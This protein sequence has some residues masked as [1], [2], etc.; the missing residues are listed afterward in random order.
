VGGDF[1]LVLK[2]NCSIAPATFACVFAA[3]AVAVLGIGIGFAM[4][5]AWLI[6]PFAGLEVIALGAAFVLHARHATDYERI[7]LAG[8]RLRV[9]VA[10]AERIARY[11]LDARRARIEMQG[12]HIVLRGAGEELRIGRHLDEE[13]RMRFAAELNNRLRT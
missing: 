9:E 4:A 6:L 5:G 13:A 3:L 10:E 8:G 11:E 7:E 1:S 12:P 2:R